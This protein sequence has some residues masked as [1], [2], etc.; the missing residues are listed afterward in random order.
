MES[1]VRVIRVE[2]ASEKDDSRHEVAVR[3]AIADTCGL[4]TMEVA[5]KLG[6]G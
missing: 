2:A 1:V 3:R 5:E 6:N 4:S